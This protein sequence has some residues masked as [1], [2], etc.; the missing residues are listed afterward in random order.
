LSRQESACIIGT[1]YITI[2]GIAIFSSAQLNLSGIS[3][4]TRGGGGGSRKLTTFLTP[5]HHQNLTARGTRGMRAEPFVNA[6]NMESMS[7]LRQNP[8][9]ISFNKLT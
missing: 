6:S 5:S 8:H 4:T 2:I 7:T 3:T 9:F 1:I